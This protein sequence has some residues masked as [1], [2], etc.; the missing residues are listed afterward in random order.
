MKTKKIIKPLIL[1]GALVLFV[2]PVLSGCSTNAAIISTRISGVE[3][4]LIVDYEGRYEGEYN[5]ASIVKDFDL[6]I[7]ISGEPRYSVSFSLNLDADKPF[8]TKGN[9]NSVY[10]YRSQSGYFS[11]PGDI[12]SIFYGEDYLSFSVLQR[13][14]KNQYL[15]S[16]YQYS[17]SNYH[18]NGKE[19]IL[20]V[21]IKL[22]VYQ[23]YTYG[24]YLDF[25]GYEGWNETEI[26]CCLYFAPAG[27][28]SPSTPVDPPPD[29]SG[30]SVFTRIKDAYVSAGYSVD[31]SELFGGD[32]GGYYTGL[33]DLYSVLGYDFCFI[34]KNLDKLLEYEV[35]MLLSAKSGNSTAEFEQLKQDFI[36]SGMACKTRNG[37]LIVS[38]NLLNPNVNFTPFDNA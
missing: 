3:F 10:R 29:P 4:E 26:K 33:K 28:Y 36:D 38:M 9:G 8:T 27:T 37:N 18:Y 16:S 30:S 12:E 21:N 19:N 25:A 5:I 15:D 32:S 17:D 34:S 7:N 23:K 20:A 22:P 6:K 1:L 2:L 35:Y 24:E 31:S 13:Y 11:V 14:D